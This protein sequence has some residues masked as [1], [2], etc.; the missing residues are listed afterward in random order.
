MKVAEVQDNEQNSRFRPEMICDAQEAAVGLSA[1]FQNRKENKTKAVILHTISDFRDVVG[2]IPNMFS[3]AK[4]FLLAGIGSFQSRLMEELNPLEEVV[5][6]NESKVEAATEAKAKRE[7]AVL[8][9]LSKLNDEIEA[10]KA[11]TERLEQ[12][13]SSL[14]AAYENIT[15]GQTGFLEFFKNLKPGRRKTLSEEA[16]IK[17]SQ[18]SDDWRSSRRK[19]SAKRLEH[20]ELESKWSSEKYR[21]N[22][23]LRSMSI[24]LEKAQAALVKKIDE[25]NIRL[26][27]WIIRLQKDIDKCASGGNLNQVDMLAIDVRSRANGIAAI[28]GKE[29]DQ[30]ANE[31]ARLSASIASPQGLNPI[32]ADPGKGKQDS[33]EYFVDDSTGPVPTFFYTGQILETA[34]D[35]VSKGFVSCTLV[36]VFSPKSKRHVAF[37]LPPLWIKEFGM[38]KTANFLEYNPLFFYGK[39]KK[40][41]EQ[42]GCDFEDLDVKIIS[43]INVPPDEVAA[44]FRAIGCDEKKIGIFQLPTSDFSTLT[45]ADRRKILVV[46][47][48]IVFLEPGRT[49]QENVYTTVG[50]N[51]G[52]GHRFY[53][54][55]G[56]S[57]Y[58][59]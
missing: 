1:N 20:G 32:S 48:E 57:R 9:Q 19:L 8:Q 2:K 34:N 47:E 59:V 11:E 12:S 3:E 49:T 52:I 58:V 39:L 13:H 33:F 15:Y 5:M 22:Q 56:E 55:S 36:E 24:N 7:A 53:S 45:L 18:A 40:F 41:I 37:H 16:R 30:F 38:T 31:F 51:N 23:D 14:N 50:G 42:E 10:L 21:S 28:G 17:A 26:Q 46:G 25:I 35:S 54:T 29:V 6:D 4:N 43:G 44:S 27:Y